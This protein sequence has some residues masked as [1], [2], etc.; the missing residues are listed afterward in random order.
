MTEVVVA[1]LEDD[2]ALAALL[3][4]ERAWAV[5]GLCD[6]EPP[7]RN[8]S[9]YI[10]AVRDG[11]VIAAV[12]IFSPGPYTSIIPYGDRQGIVAILTRADPLPAGAVFQSRQRDLSALEVRYTIRSPVAMDRMA[13]EVAAC[14]HDA[15]S[16]VR[17]HRLTSS[18]ATAL[19][20][21]Y[22][23][24]PAVAFDPAAL[25]TQIYVGAFLEGSLTAVAGTHAESVPH[26]IAAIGGVLTHPAHRNRGLAGAV[27]ARVVQ[28]LGL[29][30][31]TEAQLNVRRDNPAAIRAYARIGFRRTMS[32]VEGDLE[33]R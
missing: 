14:Q 9:R 31:I 8:R 29:Q 21:L 32:F 13:V 16:G 11:R 10:G 22:E 2:A 3:I 19:A 30:G 1:E 23:H 33:L 5:Y 7:H 28:E 20:R 15:R 25:E 27:T 17:L 6:L 26:G 4:A 12:L 24:W 18:D